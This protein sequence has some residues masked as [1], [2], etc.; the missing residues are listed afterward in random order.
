[1]AQQ[2]I[3]LPATPSAEQAYLELGR[4]LV[5][6]ADLLIAVWD[7]LPARG[8]GGTSDVVQMARQRQLPLAWIN[9]QEAGLSPVVY[10]NFERLKSSKP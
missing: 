3:R 5:T 8:P 7:G 9:A 10:E 4:Y 1:M 6:H 2:T